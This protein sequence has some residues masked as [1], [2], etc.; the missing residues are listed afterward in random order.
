MAV[1]EK[2]LKELHKNTD[3]FNRIKVFVYDLLSFGNNV[4]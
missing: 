3:F 2:S 4:T 1:Y